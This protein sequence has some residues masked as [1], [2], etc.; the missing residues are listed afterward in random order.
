MSTLGMA[1]LTLAV[2][3]VT[4]WAGIGYW[5]AANAPESDEGPSRLDSLD[6]VGGV[7]DAWPAHPASLCM[8]AGC[9]SAWEI[10]TH[11]WRECSSH[12]A[13]RKRV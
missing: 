4:V 6:S 11:G 9:P 5:A 1:V 8:H 12:Y 3:A 7:A 13:S 10:S 2:V